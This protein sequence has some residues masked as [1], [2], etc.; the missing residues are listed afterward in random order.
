MDVHS[1]GPS[2]ARA[3]SRRSSEKGVGSSDRPHQGT[4]RSVGFGIDIDTDIGPTRKHLREQRDRVRPADAGGAYLLPGKRPDLAGPVGH[5]VQPVV[6]EG[7][8]DLVGGHLHVGLEVAIAELDCPCE[9]GHRVL[10][11]IKRSAAVSDRQRP[12]LL[13]E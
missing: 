6:V 8:Q 1:R 11:P 7:H 9:R 10:P 2:A 3:R 13:Q 12:V 4:N 5:P